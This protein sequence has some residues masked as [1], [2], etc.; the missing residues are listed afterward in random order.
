[1]PPEPPTVSP[2]AVPAVTPA[3]TKPVKIAGAKGRPMLQWVGK[4]SLDQVTAFPAQIV[5][6][7]SA[8]R[9]V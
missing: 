8:D 9:L 4:R 6:A 1:M 3:E 2:A 7:Y 5:E